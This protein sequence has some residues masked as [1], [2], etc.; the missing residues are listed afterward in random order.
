M[1]TPLTNNQRL[2]LALM[3]FHSGGGSGVYAT[4]SYL[5]SGKNP[6]AEAKTRALAELRADL[7]DERMAEHHNELAR[8]IKRLERV[9]TTG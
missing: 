3:S 9:T 5:F 6:Y 1:K 7:A 2:G 4:G 8:L